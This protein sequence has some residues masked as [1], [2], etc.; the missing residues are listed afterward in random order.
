[1]S[2]AKLC[3]ICSVNRNCK[4]GEAFVLVSDTCDN[5]SSIYDEKNAFKQ[6]IAHHL[7]SSKDKIG[8]LA[9]VLSK[10]DLV[11]EDFLSATPRLKG[12]L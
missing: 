2:I 3:N 5:F 6:T 8:G 12:S 1:M 7:L 4:R 10:F 9:E 11:V